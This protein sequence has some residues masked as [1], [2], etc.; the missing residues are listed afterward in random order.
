[1]VYFHLYFI[2]SDK[3]V[4]HIFK[5]SV[6]YNHKNLIKFSSVCLGNFWGNKVKVELFI[7]LIKYHAVMKYA[8]SHNVLVSAL[9][10]GGWSTTLDF[11]LGRKPPAPRE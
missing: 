4:P 8:E 9:A 10:V 1:M 11:I 5:V 7:C 2:T 6:L 3:N